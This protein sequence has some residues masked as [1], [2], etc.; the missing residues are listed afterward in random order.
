MGFFA[1]LL[2]PLPS[3]EKRGM[4]HVVNSI[5]SSFNLILFLLHHLVLHSVFTHENPGCLSQIKGAGGRKEER[6]TEKE[7]TE[8]QSDSAG[9]GVHYSLFPSSIIYH[10]HFRLFH[11]DQIL[12]GCKSQ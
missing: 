11:L 7:R 2:E 6:P 3:K 4:F 10:V 5:T 9:N 8:L 12:R 1:T